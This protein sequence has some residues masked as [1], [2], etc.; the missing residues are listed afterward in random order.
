MLMLGVL[1]A[2]GEEG[3]AFLIELLDGERSLCESLEL[4]HGLPSY[5]RE[6]VDRV[7]EEEVEI[8]DGGGRDVVLCHL[9]VDK[10]EASGV[11]DAAD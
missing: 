1:M 11:C 3:G 7:F 6:V 4:I 2:Q 10:L 8:K 5:V 9:L